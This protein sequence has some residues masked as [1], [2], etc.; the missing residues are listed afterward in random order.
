[1]QSLGRVVAA[2]VHAGYSVPEVNIAAMDGIAVRSRDTA[3]ARE[4][5]LVTLEHAVRVNTGNII[6]PGFDAVV[7]IEETWEHGGRFRSGDRSL[8]GNM[9]GLPGRTSGR[10]TG[11][12]QGPRD[13]SLRRRCP[14][15]LWDHAGGSPVGQGRDHPHGKRA[16]PLSVSA[17]GPGRWWRAIPS[18]LRCFSPRWEPPAHGTPSYPTIRADP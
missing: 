16:G 3:G 10:T 4:Q 11:S 14:R 12:P 2:P 13:Q 15:N 1:M 5:A 18:W 9:C 17:P 8:P 6:P 7:M